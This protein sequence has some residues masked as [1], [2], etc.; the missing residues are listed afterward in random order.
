MSNAEYPVFKL[1]QFKR[2]SEGPW[3]KGFVQV[4]KDNTKLVVN[5]ERKPVLFVQVKNGWF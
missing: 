4:N 1:I 2:F 3:E 5:T